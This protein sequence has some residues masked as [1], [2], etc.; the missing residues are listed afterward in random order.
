M[1]CV[2]GHPF[3]T[4][5]VECIVLIAPHTENHVGRACKSIFRPDQL[6]SPQPLSLQQLY[7]A[8]SY[9]LVWEEASP[10]NGLPLSLSCLPV[11]YV[12]P[13]YVRATP[14][15]TRRASPHLHLDPAR[16]STVC[17]GRS[18]ERDGGRAGCVG[19]EGRVAAAAA[20][21]ESG[22]VESVMMPNREGCRC[23][24]RRDG[25]SEGYVRHRQ[26]WTWARELAIASYGGRETGYGFANKGRD[27]VHLL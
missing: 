19:C 15:P 3:I 23:P 26:T 12:G 17:I 24:T 8:I 25:R 18:K 7:L 16:G 22:G 10:H 4:V 5:C 11:A 13:L 27:G 21:M 20:C 2:W 14:G 6:S 9:C 1:L